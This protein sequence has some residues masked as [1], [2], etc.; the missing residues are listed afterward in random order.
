MA[1][2][3]DI[4]KSGTIKKTRAKPYETNVPARLKPKTII[5]DDNSNF[6]ENIIDDFNRQI[7][8]T[9]NIDVYE[10]SHVPPGNTL[11]Y[12]DMQ[13]LQTQTA[14]D[15]SNV[16]P[17]PGRSLEQDH[18]ED[19]IIM[20]TIQQ[21]VINTN[22]TIP[23]A[24]TINNALQFTIHNQNHTQQN[25]EFAVINSENV[26]ANSSFTQP[27]LTNADGRQSEHVTNNSNVQVGFNNNDGHVE[28]LLN[29]INNLQLQPQ[30]D[31][32]L[33]KVTINQ[34][35]I[36]TNQQRLAATQREF[37]NI[38][39]LTQQYY[40]FIQTEFSKFIQNWNTLSENIKSILKNKYPKNVVP[41]PVYLNITKLLKYIDSV[42]KICFRMSDDWVK[43]NIENTNVLDNDMITAVENLQMIETKYNL[44]KNKMATSSGM[45]EVKKITQIISLQN[46]YNLALDTVQTI[47]LKQSNILNI[48]A[49]ARNDMNNNRLTS[50]LVMTHLDTNNARNKLSTL[51][52]NV[53]QDNQ[54]E[55]KIDISAD[56]L[57]LANMPIIDIKTEA[58]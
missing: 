13:S 21:D 38:N 48:Y 5:T 11:D 30:T 6:P 25:N 20:E 26:R 41:I 19:D 1:D 50:P 40:T 54:N 23:D 24:Q 42:R 43:F 17:T 15:Y 37:H 56:A 10:Y 45:S 53:F 29:S 36:S 16:P 14:F 55:Y 28:I 52:E 32:K 27:L 35:D 9:E 22:E 57:D 4:Q 18:N 12:P 8:E 49:R 39:T 51:V 7:P 47:I 31:I 58:I 44:I 34:Q 46:K 3:E 33:S 2:P